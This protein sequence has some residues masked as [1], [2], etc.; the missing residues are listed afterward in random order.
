MTFA[1][2][3]AERYSKIN[4]L[5]C[6]GLDPRPEDLGS[7]RITVDELTSYVTYIISETRDYAL[8]YK[9]NVAFFEQYGLDGYEA[10][11]GIKKLIPDDIPFILDAKRGDIGDTAQAY[12]KAVFDQLCA[13]AV[14]ISGYLG[15]DSIKPFAVNPEHG[16]F[17][18]CRTSNP[19]GGE[20]QNLLL[21]D[22]NRVYEK[23]AE[24]AKELNT[25]GN[26]GLVVGA[27]CPKE[28]AVV[29]KRCPD[30]WIL[31]PGIGTQGG[32]LE[33]TL[34]AGYTKNGGLLINVSRGISGAEFPGEE[35]RDYVTEMRQIIK[36]LNC[37]GLRPRTA[38][39]SGPRETVRTHRLF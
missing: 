2:K 39:R 31:T 8:A 30:M 18:L 1:Q 26:I 16:V 37:A 21:A 12:V 15:S 24:L 11:S 4:S 34:R 3:L 27:T 7:G 35:A 20:I 36:K 33:E 9:A 13:D 25:G 22:G 28:L 5:L 19:S 17:V 23:Q 38:Y 14:T 10:L 6:V 32:D 29:R